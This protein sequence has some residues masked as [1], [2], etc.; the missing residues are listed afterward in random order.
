MGSKI[1]FW[2]I[3]TLTTSLHAGLHKEELWLKE[4]GCLEFYHAY[5]PVAAGLVDHE[6]I[7]ARWESKQSSAEKLFV[8]GLPKGASDLKY[9]E[10]Q[11]Q[12]QTSG[13][14]V[15]IGRTCDSKKILS[16]LDTAQATSLELQKPNRNWAYYIVRMAI[17]PVVG[18][19]CGNSA[20]QIER[21]LR[22]A[23]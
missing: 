17:A 6:F 19:P 14:L 18:K 9:F 16:L 5:R 13:K 3:L 11:L 21:W 15:E 4:S 12:R 10:S 8:F 23:L 1:F 2:V 20:D 7:G 22:T